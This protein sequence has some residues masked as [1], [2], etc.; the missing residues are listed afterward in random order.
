V[1]TG[2]D[3]INS[4]VFA[5]N[6]GQGDDVLSGGGQGRLDESRLR[7]EFFMG[8]GGNDLIDGRGGW[9]IASYM[10]DTGAIS[11]DMSNWG[12]QVTDGG[13][14]RDTLISVEQVDGSA[15]ADTM[16]GTS[17]TTG[18][19]AST[20]AFMGLEGND[21]IDGNGGLVYALFNRDK[22]AVTVNLSTGTATD[23]W[24]GTD[25]LRNI[26]GVVGSAFGDTLIGNASSNV[27]EGR[28][29]ND[30]ITGGGGADFV[31]YRDSQAAVNVNLAAGS[32][33]DGWG[34]TDTLLN[35][36]GVYGSVFGDTLTGSS[37]ND[38][39]VG[40]GGN[41]TIDGGSGNDE[42]RYSGPIERYNIVSTGVN[43]YVVTDTLSSTPVFDASTGLWNWGQG[44][45]T[46]TGIEKLVFSNAVYPSLPSIQG[47]AYFWNYE[48]GKGHA[49]LGGVKVAEISG[50]S[51]TNNFVSVKNVSWSPDGHVT[52]E[53][54]IRSNSA[55][56]S[57]DIDLAFD[58]SLSNLQFV[59]SATPSGFLA[60]NYFNPSTNHLKA[61]GV[62]INAYAAG[63]FKL[64]DISFDVASS[65]DTVSGHLVMG[66][67]NDVAG[68]TWDAAMS[69]TD[70]ASNG[71]YAFFNLSPGTYTVQA[72]RAATD[73]GGAVSA[74]DALAAL[75]LAVN[76]NPNTDPDGTGPQAPVAASPYQ[77]IAADV[78][79]ASGNTPDGKVTSMDALAILKMAVGMPVSQAPA[80]AWVMLP[81]TSVLSGINKDNVTWDSSTSA[82]VSG[83]SAAKVNFVGVLKGDVN[84]SW[85]APAGSALVESIDPTYF[86]KL[87]ATLSVPASQWQVI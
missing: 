11:V 5:V 28:G 63:G 46:L 17:N 77:F 43:S 75:K 15:F 31:A 14:D 65:L 87:A 49:L 83:S 29:G 86:S 60:T 50:T 72:T 85:S 34:G 2:L 51:V 73:T 37:G 45:D 47:Q 69:R 40:G 20:L 18:L 38:T 30:S 52:A 24:G 61:A 23:G 16:K 79:G 27:F 19:E 82:T 56:N 76:L 84:G 6:G 78:A 13:G 8:N 68:D 55:V 58:Q 41:D 59:Q 70:T 53:V 12:A 22:A 10:N 42:V 62:G 48:P 44:S 67:V 74:Q 33:Q 81:E 7:Y 80:A 9:D 21:T 25:T 1:Q 64:A 26:T 35:I 36:N 71:S 32:A 4:G 66:K 3:V 39:L 57:Y 54:W